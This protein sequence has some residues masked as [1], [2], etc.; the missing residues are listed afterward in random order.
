MTTGQE[1]KEEVRKRYGAAAKKAQANETGGCC[2][3]ES[4]EE[5]TISST[6][7]A[8]DELQ[9]LPQEAV[10]ASLGCGNP[11]AVAALSEG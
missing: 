6:L 4:L 1:I 11:V 3:D 9:H 10:V 2:G 7:Y 8:T 5:S